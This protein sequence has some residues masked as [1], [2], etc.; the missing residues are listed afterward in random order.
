MT[1]MSAPIAIDISRLGVR[2]YTGTERY[3]YE[4]LAALAKL[5]RFRAYTLYC[6]GLPERLPTLGPNFSLR[7]VPC[8]RLWTHAGLG[9]AVARDR[10]ALLFVPAHVVPLWHPPSVVTI[11][12][13]GYLAFPEAHTAQRRRE[14]DLTTR[15]SLRAARQVIA[16]SQATK[17][18]LVRHYAVAPERI[19]VVYHGVDQALR[20]PH[21]PQCLAELRRRYALDAPYL[22]YVGTI[23]PRKN[24]ERLIE[25]FA[26][27]L[28]HLEQP[29]LLVLAG[30]AGWLS[31]AIFQRAQ[32]LGISKH[33][34]FLGYVPDDDLPA[35]LG[36]A[37]AFVFPSLY[38][39]FGMPVLEAMAC[40]TPVLT[41]NGS[42]L[43]EVA[44]T[45]ALLVDPTNT[46]AL[47]AGMLRLTSDANLRSALRERGLARATMFTWERCA[48]ATLD[49]LLASFA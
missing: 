34:R 42:A 21:D 38:E 31:S 10:P 19:R 11:H 32:A 48:R 13:L 45:A 18:D 29:P 6:N 35:L 22:L 23:Q 15:W 24:L 2:E 16:I 5:D 25:A 7:N 1:P 47:A 44:D 33:V 20:P 43:R 27:A 41:A 4:L 3:T 37:L 39:G 26:C 28:P 46:D 40:G 12:D 17:D 14:L 36:G 49:V 8:P 9:P 30:R